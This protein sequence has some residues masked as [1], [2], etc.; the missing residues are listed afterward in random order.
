MPHQAF[1]V[2]FPPCPCR[3]P[4]AG[5]SGIS[6]LCVLRVAERCL[7]LN[8]AEARRMR[9]VRLRAITIS[10]ARRLLDA[11][12]CLNTLRRPDLITE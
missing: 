10:P 8:R 6:A 4:L 7:R 1:L 5:F 11:N 3:Y 2:R 12:V 9:L